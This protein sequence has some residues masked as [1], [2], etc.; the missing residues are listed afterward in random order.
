QP[1]PYGE[2][3]VSVSLAGYEPVL[4]RGAQVFPHVTAY[5]NVVLPAGNSDEEELISVEP[6]V[7]FGTYPE[8]IPEDEVKP[9]PEST[10]FVVLPEPVIPEFIVVHAGTLANT[11][12]PNY[13]IPYKD[14]IKNVA[15]C[16]IYATWP[17][18]A[19]IANVLAIISFTLNRVYTEWYRA[20]GYNF[21]ITSS[22]AYDHA[23]TYGRTIFAEIS[24]VVDDIFNTYITR[25]NIRQPLLTQYCDGRRVSCPNWMTQWGSKDLA[26]Q[27]YDAIDILRRFYGSEV[28]LTQ[29]DRVAGVPSSYA[30]AALR[31]GSRGQAVRTIQQQLNAI[32][33]H[34]PAIKKVPVDG[35]YGT[36]TRT[37]VET[38][39]RIFKLSS[40][41]IVGKATWYRISDIFVGVTRAAELR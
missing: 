15:S 6:P 34:Y 27:G 41:G 36:Q 10:G 16:E 13:W 37:A 3:D 9:L 40:D 31:E 38:F 28:Y 5:Q 21:T 39:Q 14:Y 24:A 12:A 20:K 26:D 29:A 4:V 8:K 19:I 2:Y 33:D 11:S 22:T 18:Q 17:E 35:V 30:G 25:P 23:F 1:Q 32:S 7:L